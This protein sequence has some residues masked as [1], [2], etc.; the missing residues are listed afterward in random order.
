MTLEHSCY[1]G[2]STGITRYREFLDEVVEILRPGGV[3]LAVDGDMQ[4]YNENFMPVQGTKEGEQVSDLYL[5]LVIADRRRGAQ[6]FTWMQKMLATA[7]SA[8]M[9]RTLS[10]S[11]YTY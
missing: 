2:V 1:V 7:L 5:Y 11:M 10:S 3:F 4:L 9:V 8:A 6:D